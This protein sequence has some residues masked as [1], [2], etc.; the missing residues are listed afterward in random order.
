MAEGSGR[1][2]VEKYRPGVL[3]LLYVVGLGGLA[4]AASV[5][6]RERDVPDYVQE[7]V[8]YFDER[9][10]RAQNNGRLADA[11]AAEAALVDVFGWVP[12]FDVA[13]AAARGAESLKS[14]VMT[15]RATRRRQDIGSDSGIA[16]FEDLFAHTVSLLVRAAERGAWHELM[17]LAAHREIFADLAQVREGIERLEAAQQGG[18]EALNPAAV[19]ISV[20][21]AAAEARDEVR[22]EILPPMNRLAAMAAVIGEADRV[23]FP[24]V[25]LGEGGLGKSVLAG[26][27]YDQYAVERPTLLILCSHLP[28][29]ADLS[30]AMRIDAALGRLGSGLEV[31][32]R[33]LAALYGR[34][35]LV[36][37]DTIDLLLR[38]ETVDDIVAVLK[39]TA[40]IAD[41]VITCR[42]RE[43]AD[44]VAPAW[45]P[46][47]W[48]LP[49]LSKPEV[50][51][52][53]ARFAADTRIP[54]VARG[55]FLDSLSLVLD[56][57]RALDVLGVPLRLAMACA[58]YAADG[59]MPD[60]LT[61]TQLYRQY[62]ERR[63]RSDRKGR[64]TAGSR[65]KEATA[66]EIAAGVWRESQARF[67]EDVPRPDA[68]HADQLLELL[69]EGVVKETGL[70]VSFFHQT[71]AE[72]SVAKR[73]AGFGGE[74][75]WSRLADGLAVGR[76]GYWGVA[77]HLLSEELNADR[78]TEISA[79][80]PRTSVEG[81]RL[82]VRLALTAPAGFDREAVLAEL[83]AEHASLLASAADVLADA[84][85]AHA[86]T[87]AEV[88]LKLLAG[89]S[90]SLTPIRRSLATLIRARADAS[91]LLRTALTTIA[92]RSTT[93]LTIAANE[94][95]QLLTSVFAPGL[96]AD[97]T[98][99]LRTAV[100]TYLALPQAGQAYL[101]RLVHEADQPEL[102][103]ALLDLALQA[104]RPDG[105]RDECV[106]I[107]VRQRA[108]P[109]IRTARGW[110]TWRAVLTAPYPT[111]WSGCQVRLV[112]TMATDETTV[113]ELVEEVLRPPA[114][115]PLDRGRLT[116]AAQLIAADHPATVAAALLEG[117]TPTRD[118]VGSASQLVRAVEPVLTRSQRLEL[119]ARLVEL[120]HLEPRKAWPTAV[121]LS[122]GDDA[123]L[124]QRLDTLTATARSTPEAD[125]AQWRV[126]AE[127]VIDALLYSAD[128]AS[129]AH[130]ADRISDVVV[131]CGGLAANFETRLQAAWVP[132]SSAARDWIDRVVDA[133]RLRARGYAVTAVLDRADDWSP[134]D[135]QATG[136]GWFVK[137]LRVQNDGAVP[138]LA[139]RLR[140][141]AAGPAWARAHTEAV[142]DR[143]TGAVDRDE[144]PQVAGSLLAVL[145]EA[146]HSSVSDR[147]AAPT[148]ADVEEILDV[149][150]RALHR[151]TLPAAKRA[152]RNLPA[153]YSQT[154]SALTDIAKT[155]LPAADLIS[156]SAALLRDLD[157]GPIGAAASGNLADLLTSV[158]RTYP[159]AWTTFEA[160]WPEA[161]E[162]NKRALA[163]CALSGVVT[164]GSDVA[165]RLA[166][167]DDCPESVAGY[168]LRLLP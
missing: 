151:A 10:R 119:S 100:G 35:P 40:E 165:L 22:P 143:L 104:A 51:A 153:N 131:A 80:I 53:A 97:R 7:S 110:D 147:S 28:A 52:L 2:A 3:R 84:P 146:A 60:D 156:T 90:A 48:P 64:V 4:D 76:S 31:G 115:G 126:V 47:T 37:I 87:A 120:A 42:E 85:E 149:Y 164:N 144:D 8:A 105:V 91:Q 155:V 89:T 62:W 118:T 112:H 92:S 44:L 134:E 75:D 24:L 14:R 114:D 70:R 138:R 27:L 159:E 152:A 41:L 69:S 65:R 72:F 161:A 82:L 77:N 83:L 11:S 6:G 109:A 135:W 139:K 32:L 98:A 168:V 145:A 73:L 1:K 141:D 163:E 123:V 39:S 117:I 74:A 46:Q 102:D 132:T 157:T 86:Q 158:V 17:T 66:L 124:A 78:L 160:A 128:P 67:V 18:S 29:S 20:S 23:A 127:G 19:A 9:K 49:A 5:N 61:V 54:T 166:R 81:V 103:T 50:L 36:I 113:H 12:Q 30:S 25:V 122:V 95:V 45:R 59:R 106:A 137:L 129:L 58:L 148:V 71:F 57:R 93:A 15:E 33:D 34:R 133:P 116:N 21:Q 125:R 101:I 88:L 150:H 56:R 26:Q 99:L 130:H 121:K 162:S 142:C 38:D 108:D 96:R 94:V 13:R 154:C 79:A 63:V 55:A 107:M 111:G 16:Y 167:R 136:L 140:I 43:W 68:A